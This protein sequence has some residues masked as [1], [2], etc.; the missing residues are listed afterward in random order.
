MLMGINS[1]QQADP[2]RLASAWCL[3]EEQ[4]GRAEISEALQVYF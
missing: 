2:F 1:L 3:Q 4:G